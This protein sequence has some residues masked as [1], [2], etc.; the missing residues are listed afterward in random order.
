[1]SFERK[2]PLQSL[3]VIE[4]AN[5]IAG[6]FCAGLFADYGADVIK[7]EQP[8]SGDSCRGM[9]PR[10][11]GESLRWSCMARNKR[12]ITLDLRK[13][14]GKEVFLKL[15][16]DAD[17]VVE[18]FKP[19]VIEKWG[20]GYDVMKSVNP[21]IILAR[22]SGYGQS[23][24][25]M[26]KP[27]FGTAGTGFSGY[28]ALHGFEGTPPVSPAISLAD[29][30]AGMFAFIGAVSAYI[31]LKNGTTDEGQV[32]DSSLYESLVRLQDGNIA[33]YALT[34][35][36]PKQDYMPRG[37]T[38]PCGTYKT[39]DGKWFIIICSTE[40]TWQACARAIGR[41]DL[42]ED[43]RFLKNP[44]RVEN[45]AILQEIVSSWVASHDLKDA[46]E[47]MDKAG[48]V[49]SPVYQ[50]DDMFKDPHYIARETVVKVPHPRFGEIAMPNI[51]PRFSGTPG[52][53]DHVGASLGEYNDEVLGE[54]GYTEE[55]IS[56]LREKGIL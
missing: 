3:R 53:I 36:I 15:V 29:F 33:N 56:E 37:I 8:G 25:Y 23:G 44:D 38:S 45:D 4:I 49:S 13:P 11:D 12:N 41:E 34:G 24:P 14:E 17:I 42:I 46:W 20:I 43:P 1:M 39:R 32:V 18:N 16:K 2:G 9:G 10:L 6:P 55:Q 50:V 47:T 19:G 51:N 40:K 52:H 54:I 35:T 27:G 31:A 28:T 48:A 26:P 30:E 22:I 7:I 21:K 5:V